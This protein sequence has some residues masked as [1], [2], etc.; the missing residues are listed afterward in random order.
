MPVQRYHYDACLAEYSNNLSAIALLKQYRPYLEIIPS[1]RRPEESIITIPL[2]IVRL[3]QDTKNPAE[4]VCL[5]CDLAILTCDPEW[6]IKSGA[7]IIIFIH[8]PHEDFSHLLE[9]WRKTQVW[10]DKSYEWLMPFRYKHILSEGTNTVYPLFVIFPETPQ[11]IQRG[12]VGANLPFV[13]L[14]LESIFHEDITKQEE[15]QSKDF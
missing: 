15:L 3:C 9:R 2:P 8:R 5:P 4:A 13:I 14:T 1:L 6:K 7:E 12:L 10:L 11:R